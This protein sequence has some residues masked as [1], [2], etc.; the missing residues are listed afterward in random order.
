MNRLPDAELPRPAHQGFA[1]PADWAAH[2]RTWMCWPCRAETW[3]SDEAMLNAKLATARIARAISTFEPVV[4]AVRHEDM[5]AAKLATAS[6]VQLFE[7]LLDDSW[8]RD[9]GPTFLCGASGAE[10]AVQWRFNAWGGKYQPYRNDAGLATRIAGHSDLR[11]FDAPIVCEGGAI[12]TDGE[13][14]LITTE[15]CLLNSNRNPGLI[16]PELDDW[17][18]HFTG[19]RQVIWLGEGFSDMETDGHVDNIACFAAPGRVIVGV[20]SSPSL[21]DARPVKEAIRRLKAARDAQGRALEIIEMPQPRRVRFDWRG[22]M[23]QASYVNFYFANGGIVMP[24]FDDPNDDKAQAILADCFP[25]RD[26]LQVEVL[27]LLQGG[28]GIHCI[29][30]GEPA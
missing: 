14:T 20:P 23:L 15:Q 26:I 12:H 9:T 27:D 29:A 7:T 28:G 19:A 2:A 4:L 22:R 8:A 3:G 11:V 13:G 21:P 30:L 25:G 16:R 24:A 10:A 17:L 6:K 1:M 18:M 5:A